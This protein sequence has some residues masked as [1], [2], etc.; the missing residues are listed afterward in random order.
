[1]LLPALARA[2]ESARRASCLSNIK[3][4]GLAMKQYS[5]D[6]KEVY[7]W[8]TG[9]SEPNKAWCD[10]GLLFPNYC[11]AMKTFYC[12][13]GNDRMWDS[14]SVAK[15]VA[16]PLDPFDM[17]SSKETISYSYSLDNRNGGSKP[18]TEDAKSTVRLLADK[19]AGTE[20]GSPGNAANC[21]NHKDDGR[22]VMYQDGHVRWKAG[23]GALDPDEDDYSVGAPHKADYT[24]WWCDPPYYGEFEM[25]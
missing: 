10:L 15:K 24:R 5:Q 22:N 12:P 17:N 18:W 4:L 21:A 11:S 9:V 8:R 16:H 1:M 25:K 2:R 19:K 14:N 7:P 13:S 20:I 23:P 6:F 3:Q